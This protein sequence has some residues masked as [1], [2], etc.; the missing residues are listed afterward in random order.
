M[1]SVFNGSVL[2]AVLGVA[3]VAGAQEAAAPAAETVKAPSA[4]AVRD[5]WNFFYKGQG[6]GPVLVEAKLC[7]EVA[8]DGPNKYECT[9]EVGPEGIKAGTTVML[10]QSYLV[11]QGD[12][13]EDLTV[14]V[15][16]G[17]TVRETKDVKVKGEGWRA[18]QWTGVKLAKPGN[19][20][21]V[22][23][24]GDQVLKEVPVKVL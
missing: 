19:W 24:R 21:V 6:Q 13:V 9:A 23:M 17:A 10:W 16:Q 14:Q 4:D 12:S 2:C 20:T 7:T 15:K 3:S 18:R 11:P 1:K 22:V 8:K 5:T